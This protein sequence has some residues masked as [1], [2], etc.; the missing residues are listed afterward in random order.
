MSWLIMINRKSA[1]DAPVLVMQFVLAVFAAPF[2]VLAATI[3]SLSAGPAFEVPV[4]S[5]IVVLKCAAVACLASLGHLLLYAATMRA[6]AAVIAPTTY[7]QIM[8]AS[9]LGWLWFGDPPD[10]ATLGGAVLI[11]LGGLWLWRSQRA[12]KAG[13]GAPG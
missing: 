5:P 11:I 10:A 12:P 2:L 8:M 6:S 9:L 3:L 4:P 1:G 13:A 7:V